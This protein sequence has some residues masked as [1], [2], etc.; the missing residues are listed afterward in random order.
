MERPKK[1]EVGRILD[2]NL[3]CNKKN[4]QMFFSIPRRKLKKFLKD[5]D[6]PKSVKIMIKEFK[7]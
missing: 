2:R 7:W 1:V 3:F 6:R 4:N 5:N